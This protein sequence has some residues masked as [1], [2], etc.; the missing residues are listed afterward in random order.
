MKDVAKG[1]WREADELAMVQF[2]PHV[3]MVVPVLRRVPRK[4]AVGVRDIRA[5]A[6][7]SVADSDIAIDRSPVMYVTY[8]AL[9]LRC[10]CEAFGLNID[11]RRVRFR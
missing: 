11:Q 4:S 7:N 10:K 3:A 8:V 2:R 6:R 5:I 1:S 9:D